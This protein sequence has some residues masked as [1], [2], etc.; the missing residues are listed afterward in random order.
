M[1]REPR[2]T[3][4]GGARFKAFLA[5]VILIAFIFSAVKIVPALVN[6]YELQDSIQEEATF[7][8]V[9]RKT[10]DQ[11]IED[12]QKKLDSLGIQASPKAIQVTNV[13]GQVTIS[14]DYT[15]PIDLKVYQFQLHFHP[16]ANNTSI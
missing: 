2:N 1:L 9:N 5:L 8:A 4:R 7:A 13:S 14:V 6:N 11:V 16:Q 15:V 3:E 10:Q 12:V